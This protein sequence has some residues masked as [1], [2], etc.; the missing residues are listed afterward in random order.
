MSFKTIVLAAVLAVA[1]VV[2]ASANVV[3]PTPYATSPYGSLYQHIIDD[4]VFTDSNGLSQALHSDM[5]VVFQAVEQPTG[6][7]YNTAFN[8][9][10]SVFSGDASNT[11]QQQLYFQNT[12]LQRSLSSSQIGLFSIDENYGQNA[13]IDHT[14]DDVFEATRSRYA[15]LIGAMASGNIKAALTSPPQA[16]QF[17]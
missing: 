12:T 7:N 15:D 1:M 2:R 10:L 8:V 13:F 4:I 14:S 9:T 5:L 17:Q 16:L 3:P 6:G 11:R